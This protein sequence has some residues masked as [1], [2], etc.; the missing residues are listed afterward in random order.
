LATLCRDGTFT[1]ERLFKERTRWET[2]STFHL[3]D[4]E[5]IEKVLGQAKTWLTE[6]AAKPA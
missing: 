6:R 4:I 5:R 1:V 2:V 3:E